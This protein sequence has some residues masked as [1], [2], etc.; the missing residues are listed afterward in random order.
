MG[1]GRRRRPGTL[2]IIGVLALALLPSVAPAE[3]VSITATVVDESSLPPAN[4]I[5]QFKGVAA[6]SATVTIQRNGTTI[7]TGTTDGAAAFDLTLTDQPTGQQV[8]DITAVDVDGRSLTPMTFA[9]NLTAG[10]TTI[11][12]GIFLGPSIAID[13]TAVKLGETVT[14]AGTTLPN[15]TV[16]VTVNSVQVK[17][18]SFLADGNG[19]WSKAIDTTDI[20]VGTHSAKA[21]AT[22]SGTG[23]SEYSASVGFAVNPLAQCDGKKSADLNCDG[24]INLT[25]FSVLLFFWLQVNPTNARSDINA[26]GR[27]TIT[28]FSIMLF[29][30]TG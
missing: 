8:Y 12:L 14:V 2:V 4:P 7:T 17:N 9:L 30:W 25:D 5:V 16:T 24:R 1:W 18:Y 19:R 15:S 11:I 27:V 6:P 13:K 3:T 22:A 28:D 26:D 20:G 10:S 23:V 29:Q 21:R